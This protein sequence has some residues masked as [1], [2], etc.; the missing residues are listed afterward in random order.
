MCFIKHATAKTRDLLRRAYCRIRVF[1]VPA[2][3]AAFS[4]LFVEVLANEKKNGEKVLT[5]GYTTAV[6]RF[7]ADAP[8]PRRGPIAPVLA[9]P[10]RSPGRVGFSV[11]AQPLAVASMSSSLECSRVALPTVA[12]LASVDSP[13]LRAHHLRSCPVVLHLPP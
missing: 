7:F 5:L 9:L 12:V 3:P 10:H 6:R 1:L 8:R 2:L 11:A 13:L 4:V